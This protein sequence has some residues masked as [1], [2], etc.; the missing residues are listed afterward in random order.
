MSPIFPWYY[1]ASTVSGKD[2]VPWF[3]HGFVEDKT[4]KYISPYM[5]IPMNMLDM[6]TAGTGYK[7]DKIFR[8]TANLTF[9]VAY[10]DELSASHV[11]QNFPHYVILYYVNDSDGETIFV[12]S[13]M[14]ISPVA[15]RFV[16][17]DGTKTHRARLVKESK[18]RIV[19]NFNVT[20]K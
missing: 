10:P 4:G 8:I 1:S 7:I 19:F 15:G 14:E 13:G 9:P 3:F 16:I 20:L 11:D 12:D 18:Q 17:F 6:F 5:N 2:E